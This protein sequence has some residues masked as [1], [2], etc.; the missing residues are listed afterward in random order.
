[1][2]LGERK[3]ERT[4]LMEKASVFEKTK[5]DYLHQIFCL[6]NKE[7]IAA[8]LG[9][10][11]INSG[12]RIPFFQRTYT[13]TADDVVDVKGKAVA[14]AVSVI[15]CK[16]LLLCPRKPSQDHSLVTYKD[17]KDAAPLVRNFRSTVEQPISVTFAHRIDELE[18]RCLELGGEH[19]D[20][21]V[22]CQLAM[23]FNALPR[24]PII[25]LYYD[26]D[27][28][29]SAQATLLFQKNVASY[30]DMECLAM[31]GGVLA[32]RLAG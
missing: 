13:I 11:V 14:Y 21:E 16:Y 20:A 24:V 27:E 22:S 23:R 12:F 19:F 32:H 29:F 4:D 30:L 28:E 10:S 5:K 8:I 18:K 17:F 2:A 3:K 15:L 7:D 6:D 1:M 25:L 26:A 31:I 9:C